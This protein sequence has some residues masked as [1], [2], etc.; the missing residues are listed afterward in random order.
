[1]SETTK[2]IG[3]VSLKVK[4]DTSDFRDD[5][6]RGLKR[7]T[8]GLDQEI[9]V[10]AK[11]DV[12]DAPARRKLE[13]LKQRARESLK[14][15]VE[16]DGVSSER[17]ADYANDA[18]K[19]IRD[20]QHEMRKLDSDADNGL[21]R[22]WAKR[23]SELK[24]QLAETKVLMRS[25]VEQNY[26]SDG[27]DKAMGF[28]GI[29]KALDKLHG[30]QQRTTQLS[31]SSWDEAA[32]AAERYA[33]A[34][35]RAHQFE[36]DS[37]A[38]S[39]NDQTGGTYRAELSKNIEVLD[40]QFTRLRETD[41]R[42]TSMAKRWDALGKAQKRAVS[43]LMT[44]EDNAAA[45]R[46][47]QD[48]DDFRESLLSMGAMQVAN[49]REARLEAEKLAMVEA[50]LENRRRRRQSMMGFNEGRQTDFTPELQ[51]NN[52]DQYFVQREQMRQYIRDLESLTAAEI[53]NLEKVTK[54]TE[55]HDAIRAE[56]NRR[57][58][59]A[60]FN[61]TQFDQAR[62]LSDMAR[63]EREHRAHQDRL[64]K[65]GQEYARQYVEMFDKSADDWIDDMPLS[66][67][68]ESFESFSRRLADRYRMIDTFSNDLN[69]NVK[70]DL[71]K[72][73]KLFDEAMKPGQARRDWETIKLSY[74]E[75]SLRKVKA[76]SDEIR[77]DIED[78]LAINLDGYAK[79]F[80]DAKKNGADQTQWL[81][82][83]ARL[84]DESVKKVKQEWERL[85]KEVEDLSAEVVA[86]PVGF[87]AV[88]AH[89]KYLTRPRT[90]N[91]FVKIHGKSL[92]VAKDTLKGLGGLNIASDIGERFDDA[93][94]NIDR[95]A[96]KLGKLGTILGSVGAGVGALVGSIASIGAGVASSVGIL[97]MLPAVSIAAAA[98]FGVFKI[99]FSD[100]ANAFSDIPIVAEEAL[101]SLPP[102]AR[103][104]VEE[105][106]GTWTGIR[107]PVQEAFWGQMG[108]SIG[109]LK[110]R[111]LPQIRDGLL[112][113]A[114]EAA[115]ATK[116][117]LDSFLKIAD[118][119][120]MK[121]MLDNTGKM[122]R[123]AA[124][125]AEPL[126]DA[127]NRIGLRGSE[128]LP[129]LGTWMAD[130]A[131]GFDEW[132]KKADEAGKIDEWIE[133]SIQSFKD[134]GS[135]VKGAGKMLDGLAQSALRAGGPTLGDLAR[136]L[137]DVGDAMRGEPFQS[138][139]STLFDG[140]FRGAGNLVGG[141]KDIGSAIGDNAPFWADLLDVTT[142]V[143]S[144]QFSNVAD[145]L[146]NNYMQ[147]G[148]IS[149]F[150]GLLTLTED[151]APAF[152]NLA[153]LVGDV[154]RVAESS[155]KNAGPIINTI[156]GGI[157]DVVSELTDGA[158]AAIP[159]ITDQVN[160]G[161][162][163]LSEILIPIASGAG[164]V[165][166][167]FGNLPEPIQKAVT[168]LGAFVLMKGSLG[169]LMTMI[170]N[171]KPIANMRDMWIANAL[172]AGKTED[173]I[174]KTGIAT[175][176]FQTAGGHVRSF[177]DGI[178][179]S[180]K[181]MDTLKG[182]GRGLF[183]LLG[184]PWGLALGAAT[185]A[186][187]LWA[188]AQADARAKA[189]ELKAT[190]DQSTGAITAATEATLNMALA[191]DDLNWF[192]DTILGL[193]ST[194]EAA[195]KFGVK[196]TDLARIVAE[197]GS[198]YDE[199]YG[200]LEQL[201]GGLDK[202]YRRTVDQGA[203]TLDSK[204]S[205][206]AL[207]DELGIVD[208]SITGADINRIKKFMDT[209]RGSITEAQEALKAYNSRTEELSAAT[210]LSEGATMRLQ[211]ALETL[212]GDA[213][214]ADQ[215]LNALIF[216]MDAL[217]G[218]AM[219]A[220]DAAYKFGKTMESTVNSF[221]ELGKKNNLDGLIDAEGK[222]KSLRGA[223][224][225]LR[226][227]FKGVA[228]GLIE[229]GVAAAEAAKNSGKSTTEV[230][231]AVRKAMQM[232]DADIKA[233]SEATG[234][235]GD[236]I[237]TTLE[238]LTGEDWQIAAY[239]SADNELFSKTVAEAKAEGR[240]LTEKEWKAILSA[241]GE[242]A[243][244]A[245]DAVKA[246]GFE[247]NDSMYS[248]Y[249]M[250]DD[251]Q[252]KQMLGLA[253]D[254]G[255]D[256]SA[257]LYEAMLTGNAN[258]ALSVA[259]QAKGAGLDFSMALYEAY[260]RGD[261]AVFNAAVAGAGE[262][263]QA[264]AE[265]VYEAYL[266]ANPDPAN[267]SAK[268]AQRFA[269][270]FADGDYT[271]VLWGTS[272]NAKKVIAD[273][274]AK[275]KKF[276][277]DDYTAMLDALDKTDPGIADSIR[278]IKKMTGADYAAIIKA[279]NGTKPGK[280][281]SQK[282]IDSTKGVTRGIKAKNEAQDGKGKAQGTINSTKGVTRDIKASN[283]AGGGK[284]SAQGTINSTKGKTVDIK[285]SNQTASGKAKVRSSLSGLK[286]TAK[287][288]GSYTGWSAWPRIKALSVSVRGIWAGLTG[289]PG[290]ANGA[291]YAGGV[292][293]A[294]PGHKPWVAPGSLAAYANGG[295]ESH[296]AQIASPTSNSIRI[297]AEPET[298]GEAYIPLA[299]SKRT[300]S[301]AIWEETGKRLGTYADG[302]IEGAGAAVAGRGPT[303][304]ITNNYPV[305]EKTSTTI[306]RALQFAGAPD[307]EN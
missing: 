101:K 298:G 13:D 300:R 162:Q 264:F 156:V 222:F 243:K 176:A 139:M 199:L 213:S 249:L 303:F 114:P 163:T 88:A 11:V 110:K 185:I 244:A 155:F 296:Q 148:V 233:L 180:S 286:F 34:V 159:G 151:L 116:G 227:G 223:G 2:L 102:L 203:A 275:G 220:E 263:G 1:M 144:T 208:K 45:E 256:F 128:Y 193:D 57:R 123:N 109:Q 98:S 7:Q 187:S 192:Q 224:G 108:D 84:D 113:L 52:N 225:E 294:I 232:S 64:L 21:A 266:A 138:Q 165:L 293:Q 100:F 209:N 120:Q 284:N 289:G 200:K 41:E 50:E 66:R 30:A 137:N 160:T 39:W 106:R 105:L 47:K 164:D 250:G 8:K 115:K 37:P 32:K 143:A 205:L 150:N 145:F 202:S 245:M 184:G 231:D 61:G 77:R 280:D 158:I 83:K 132:I 191:G 276:S 153:L 210:G 292:A 15:D 28:D 189:D 161:L 271:A 53:K 229:S 134:M 69:V 65:Q 74:D 56:I 182:A 305:A 262:K 295:I 179:D 54:E 217:N 181:R 141:L 168:A 299:A 76:R 196:T 96:L 188:N 29:Q 23:K 246:A 20:L 129:R 247:W 4:P 240:E 248:A 186:T 236:K 103:K 234:I 9:K 255:V 230:A 80:G 270:E 22:N 127:I 172:A 131:K 75:E 261:S 239:L 44:S 283:K 297:W 173:A 119:G 36:K 73:A 51:N 304:N 206:S 49:L 111:I 38:G 170:G 166:E 5:A 78:S 91:I 85:R 197:G 221:K 17:W 55:K 107:I 19:R 219:S 126:F 167:A 301:I 281:S 6:E 194:G 70:E 92:Q 89:L 14:V 58:R 86:N 25:I 174:R 147:G 24:K 112:Q 94:R 268:Q 40:K 278:A 68:D 125:G 60:N 259:R 238:G 133:T 273:A 215:K 87:M 260:L 99:A 257:Q 31:K 63:V 149:A 136:G 95:H 214:T 226:E 237:R 33:S 258:D 254:G 71:D 46:A 195:E 302:G 242:Q 228:K 10:K 285:A 183:G 59:Q 97:A 140:A 216:T 290:N 93:F 272:E 90:A 154:G 201:S 104:A 79:I 287:V 35:D 252:W 3:S 171:V 146:R 48:L 306:N 241:D 67:I 12:D 16:L 277:K 122:M 212:S 307:F 269:E 204:E 117:V 190:L 124:E 207:A 135:A 279:I 27:L 198:E 251:E 142:Q 218:G 121:T 211:G 235:S 253:K 175:M 82:L 274:A 72:L 62:Q 282:T 178:R 157:Q 81:E 152:D 288:A 267:R 43:S 18:K 130:G 169:G 291:I 42:L 26:D 265:Q 177:G 118:N